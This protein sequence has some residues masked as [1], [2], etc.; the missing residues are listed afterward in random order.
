M[1]QESDRVLPNQRPGF[2][3][4]QALDRFASTRSMQYLPHDRLGYNNIGLAG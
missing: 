2:A 4:A 1:R 3:S